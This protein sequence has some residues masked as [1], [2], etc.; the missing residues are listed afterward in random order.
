VGFPPLAMTGLLRHATRVKDSCIHLA[1]GMDISSAVTLLT[2][3][4]SSHHCCQTRIVVWPWSP[5]DIFK[6][7][8][9]W[10]QAIEMVSK[11]H[12]GLDELL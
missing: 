5:P 3:P 6:A 9:N 2:L 10:S 12:V 11:A 1:A 8:T 4:C 7:M